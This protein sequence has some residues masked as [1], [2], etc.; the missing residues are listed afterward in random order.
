MGYVFI[1]LAYFLFAFLVI[2]TLVYSVRLVKA[3]IPVLKNYFKSN[4]KENN[5]FN[6]N[7]TLE[8]ILNNTSDN[9]NVF[10][11]YINEINKL[12]NICDDNDI[13][14]KL[15]I[16]KVTLKDV[17]DY[18]QNNHCKIEDDMK[19]ITEHYVNDVLEQI[20]KYLSLHDSEYVEKYNDNIKK[21][22]LD[23]I[24]MITSAYKNILK[25]LYKNEMISV[26]ANLEALKSG[27]KLK[28]FPTK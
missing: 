28:G 1:I 2:I 9:E 17:Y 19:F 6:N 12:E 21:S 11:T 26:S 3:L 23:S 4:S 10:T 16:L 24:D 14:N 18:S 5:P 8:T 15:N 25:E 7:N 20:E 27:I 13:D 22:I